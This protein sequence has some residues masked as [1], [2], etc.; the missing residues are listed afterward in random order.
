MMFEMMRK[1]M[2]RKMKKI[3]NFSFFKLIFIVLVFMAGS[4]IAFIYIISKFA[5][6]FFNNDIKPKVQN[7]VNFFKSGLRM[8]YFRKK[9]SVMSLFYLLGACSGMLF[10][11]NFLCIICDKY[12]ILSI[13][14]LICEK[15]L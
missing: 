10:F 8:F 2:K 1:I 14:C 11:V 6:I 12:Y 5:G 15:N 3:I 7:L 13:I 4:L 9:F